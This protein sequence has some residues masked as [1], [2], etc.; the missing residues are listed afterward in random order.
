M[1]SSFANVGG[2]A[3]LGRSRRPARS[4]RRIGRP[5]T[6]APAFRWL[7][8]ANW[9]SSSR[10]SP[11]R[12][13]IRSAE[14]PWLALISTS[15]R[16]DQL[17][18]PGGRVVGAD[19]N[20]RHRLDAAGDHDVGLAAGDGLGREV[21]GL[22]ARAAHPVQADGRHLDREAGLQH[23]EPRDVGALLADL[24]HAA[25]GSRRPPAPG[26]TPARRTSSDSTSAISSSG[27]MSLSEPLRRPIGVRTASTITTSSSLTGHRSPP[28][29]RRRRQSSRERRPT[30]TRCEQ[31]G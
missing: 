9:S 28:P 6:P 16:P 20:P 15:G 14:M 25:R 23:G 17:R 11:Q 31:E 30:R 8:Y 2:L 7:S 24:G 1:P 12:S 21:D 10:V 5:R 3:V 26:S 29:R 4:A 13:A 19:R 18:A 22:L 27:R